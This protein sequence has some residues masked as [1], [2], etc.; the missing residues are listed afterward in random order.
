MT[1]TGS[2]RK[3]Y[4]TPVLGLP[5]ARN[6]PRYLEFTANFTVPTSFGK[7]GAILVT[8][9]L[10][11]EICLSEILIRDGND[12]I[13]FPGDTWIHSRN[14]NPESRI[15]FRNQVNNLLLLFIIKVLNCPSANHVVS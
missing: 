10:S 3:S 2:G 1:E 15:I 7:P 6:D 4:E 13:L 11:T 5:K 8:N 12:T 9:L 14:D